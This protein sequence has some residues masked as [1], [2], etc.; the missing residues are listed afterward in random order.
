MH[1]FFAFKSVSAIVSTM[2]DTHSALH[3][4]QCETDEG[5]TRVHLCT[6]EA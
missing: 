3:P 6:S 1:N 5:K 4:L 2:A